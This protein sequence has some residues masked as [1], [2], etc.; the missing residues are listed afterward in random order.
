MIEK[1]VPLE[2][3]RG[4]RYFRWRGGETSRLEG[5][6]DAVFALAMTLLIVSVEVPAT[7]DELF[8]LFRRL[9]AFA[10]CFALF[11]L[12]WYYH[13]QFHRRFGLENLYTIFLNI[14]LLFLILFYVY[15]TKFLF[16]V[17]ADVWIYG[18]RV[19]ISDQSVSTL[20]LFYSGGVVGIFLLFTLMYL[21]AF[22]HR[23]VLGLSD[24]EVHLTRTTIREHL[25]HTGVGVASILLALLGRPALSG[26]IYVA[27]GPLQGLNGWLSGRAV[28]AGKVF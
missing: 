4:E 20:M 3:L 23:E 5:L 25:I 6:T 15:P 26:L 8:D 17:L 16:T 7:P 14:C 10:V 11:V 22:K 12:L 2:A 27:V 19:K 24:I 18:E 21:H 13:Y 1:L 9:P 28:R